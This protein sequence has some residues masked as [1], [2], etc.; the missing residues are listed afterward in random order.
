M[1]KNRTIIIFGFEMSKGAIAD[2]VEEWR[3]RLE[4][5]IS[6]FFLSNW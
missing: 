6:P 3:I 4:L 1:L 5:K 2:M